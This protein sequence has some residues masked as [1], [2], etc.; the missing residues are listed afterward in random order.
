MRLQ[1]LKSCLVSM[2]AVAAACGGVT[3]DDVAPVPSLGESTAP[4][5]YPPPAPASGNIVDSTAYMG[6]V[7]LP[8][9]IQTQFTMTPQYFSFSFVVPAGASS[10]MKLEV[11]HLGSSMYLDTGL[12]LYGPRQANGSYGTTLVAVDDDSGYGQLSRIS[13]VNVVA[14][15]EYLVV[16]SSGSGAG[17]Q[18]RLQTSCLSGGCV[19][20]S[21][22]TNYTLQLNEQPLPPN[23]AEIQEDLY[24]GCEGACY[25]WLKT[26]DFPF[27]F[28]G[29]PTLAMATRAVEQMPFFSQYGYY[30]TGTF[31]YANLEPQLLP[32]FST[33]NVPQ[34]LLSTYWNGVEAVQVASYASPLVGSDFK[35]FVILFPESRRVVTIE[36]EHFW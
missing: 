30:A 25:G 35:L 10:T 2:L 28:T 6:R 13:A 24:W 26:Y 15:G 18:F 16:V 27:P 4:V 29:Q 5:L 32:I 14:G 11:T 36:Q 1:L 3:G 20:Q 31:P 8:G 17:K 21:A 9:S 7:N 33:L 34:A 12:F 23:L 22:P 19:T